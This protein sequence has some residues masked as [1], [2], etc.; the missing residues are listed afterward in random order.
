MKIKN[1]ESLYIIDAE[2]ES[3]IGPSELDCNSMEV[4]DMKDNRIVIIELK[5]GKSSY[6]DS[7]GRIIIDRNELISL[8]KK[9]LADDTTHK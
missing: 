4:L 6:S 2:E 3:V 1:M 8:A 5:K 7:I 9:I